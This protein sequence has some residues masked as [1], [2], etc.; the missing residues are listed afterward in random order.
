MKNIIVFDLEIKN[1]IGQCGV[2]WGTHD[3]MGLSCAVA[4]RFIED[5]YLV[6]DDHNVQEL[7]DILRSADLVVGYNHLNFDYKVLA[8]ACGISGL[9]K[10]TRDFDLLAEIWKAAGKRIKNSGLGKVCESTLGTNKSGDGAMAP[11]LYQ[12]GKYA[13]LVSYCIQDVKL[14]RDLF[15]M[16][17]KIST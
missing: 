1:L 2:T 3:K 10:D 5:D 16:R 12:Q 9:G 15:A 13:E 6:F 11:I 8:K 17:G 4:Y 14:T 7:G